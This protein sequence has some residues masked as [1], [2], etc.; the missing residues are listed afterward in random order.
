MSTSQRS[1]TSSVVGTASGHGEKASAISS[2]VFRKNSLVSK[3]SFGCSSVDLVCTQ[4]S[5]AWF[6]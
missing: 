2:A 5:A 4:S 6:L 3:L 1:A